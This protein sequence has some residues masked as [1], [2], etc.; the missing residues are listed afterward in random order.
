MKKRGS[1]GAVLLLHAAVLLFG[2]SGVIAKY[3]SASAIVIT[4][5]RVIFSSVILLAV[6]LIKKEGFGLMKGDL[7]LLCAAGGVQAVHWVTFFQSIKSASVAIGTLTFSTFPLFLIFLE[8]L[9]FREKFRMKNL[10]LAAALMAGVIITVPEFST[11][12][13]I[14]MGIIWGMVCSFTYAILSLMNRR[15]AS[16]YSGVKVCFFE[17]T[18]AAIMLSPVLFTLKELPGKTDIA[19]MAVIGALCTA[20]AFSLFV[21]AQRSISAQTAGIISGMETVYGIILAFIILREVPSAREFIGGSV[22]M[23]VAMLSSLSRNRS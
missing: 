10:L 9:V 4:L 19:G 17:Q 5:G 22:I 1:G 7:L 23:G 12:N 16:R 3:I 21:T 14:T 18:A 11:E 13:N 8:P 15:F 2:L 20:L 6:M